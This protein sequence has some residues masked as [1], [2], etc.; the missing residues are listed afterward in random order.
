MYLRGAGILR[1]GVSANHATREKQVIRV[2]QESVTWYDVL[3]VNAGASAVTLRRAYDERALLLRAYRTAE[4]MAGAVA[5]AASSVEE[6]WQ[7]LGDPE[8]R[9]RYDAQLRVREQATSGR[10]AVPDVRGLFYRSSQ[11]IAAMAGLPLAVIRLTADPLPVEGLVVGQSPEPGE[12]IRRRST[13]TVE[14]WH[15]GRAN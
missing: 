6:A 4:P 14:V 9:K 13:L 8:R 11:G 1:Q 15:P 12:T 2:G 5:R 3:G 10:P 7:V